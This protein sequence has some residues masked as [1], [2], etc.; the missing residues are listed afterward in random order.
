[1][2]IIRDSWLAYLVLVYMFAARLAA[3]CTVPLCISY[4]SVG[5]EA[6]KV[7]RDAL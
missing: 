4:R 7:T 2:F 1:M 3:L 6:G 5:R